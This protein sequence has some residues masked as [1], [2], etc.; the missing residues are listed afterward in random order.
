LIWQDADHFIRL[1]RNV[2]IAGGQRV[3][4]PPLLEQVQDGRAKPTNPPGTLFE[5][6]FRGD[7]T[8]FRLERKD[9]DVSASYSHDGKEWTLFKTIPVSMDETVSVG[10]AAINTS[11]KPFEVVFGDLQV[12]GREA[13]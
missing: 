4:Y 3:C 2:W 1:E 8:W 7:S 9:N 12:S 6:F 10:V 13:D 5:S 11:K